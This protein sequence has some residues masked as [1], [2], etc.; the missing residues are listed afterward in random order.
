MATLN[1]DGSED[2]SYRY[3]MPRLVSKVEGRGNGVKTVLVNCTDLAA[4]LNRSTGQVTKFFG[5]H[6]GA[7]TKLATEKDDENSE[8]CI[9][10]GS[11]DNKDLQEALFD[12]IKKF[13]LC[14]N[15]G[16]PETEQLLKGGKKSKKNA[17]VLLKCKACGSLAEADNAHKLCTFIVKELS[18]VDSDSNGKGKKK[19]GKKTKKG[20]K[21]GEKDDEKKAKKRDKEKDKTSQSFS[22]SSEEEKELEEKFGELS[23]AD[24]ASLDTA[25]SKLSS[26]VSSSSPGA[27]ISDQDIAT[28]LTE[29]QRGS[30]LDKSC[31]LPILV[32]VLL[33]NFTSP[34]I[35]AK[36][37]TAQALQ[38]LKLAKLPKSNYST[39]LEF[40]REIFLCIE[41]C[42]MKLSGTEKEKLLKVLPLIVKQL[43]DDGVLREGPIVDWF[44]G[45]FDPLLFRHQRVQ[46]TDQVAG[47]VKKSVSLV[48]DWF[49]D[50]SE[51]DSDSD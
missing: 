11:H 7:M 21:N 44:H 32:S 19:K 12:Y 45:K 18:L 34:A 48:I 50:D 24:V 40:Q 22:N 30:G 41:E 2:P 43:Y 39:D 6:L 8:K 26:F 1:V 10:N 14:P 25:I 35:A 20:E 28:K 49:E 27:I 47:E 9:V 3:K 36:L 17:T 42:A 51:S 13:V 38:L 5:C 33:L 46:V 16:N 23:V 29:V 37:N 4:S 31:Q 15:C